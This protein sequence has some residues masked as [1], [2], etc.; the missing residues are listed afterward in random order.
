ME[1]LPIPIH[2]DED[3][4]CSFLSEEVKME[5]EKQQSFGDPNIPTGECHFDYMPSETIDHIL[6]FI[7]Y[8]PDWQK[9]KLLSKR[10]L[11]LGMEAFDPTVNK[12]EP[13]SYAVRAFN[14]D[15]VKAILS[16]KKMDVVT[17]KVA[18][19]KIMITSCKS[20]SHKILS[21]LL[22]ALPVDRTIWLGLPFQQA[23]MNGTNHVRG[24]FLSAIVSHQSIEIEDNLR[25]Y[26]AVYS[27]MNGDHRIMEAILKRE[28]PIDIGEVL[29]MASL[30]LDGIKRQGNYDMLDLPD[31]HTI[32]YDK[33]PCAAKHDLPTIMLLDCARK[34]KYNID[35]ERPAMAH[36]FAYPNLWASLVGVAVIHEKVS[37][38]D[39]LL[40]HEHAEITPKLVLDIQTTSLT[41]STE[42]G[43]RLLRD[44]R[45]L[46]GSDLNRP[47]Q[48]GNTMFEFVCRIGTTEMVRLYLSHEGLRL[49]ESGDQPIVAAL[50]RENHSVLALLI[51]DGRMVPT[52]RHL[53]TAICMKKWKHVNELLRDTRV[54]PNSTANSRD[55]YPFMVALEIKEDGAD[56][57]KN[58]I[59]NLFSKCKRFDPNIGYGYLLK[60]AIILNEREAITVLTRNSKF[61]PSKHPQALRHA[62]Q[63][64]DLEIIRLVVREVGLP[65]SQSS[66]HAL[67]K[68]CLHDAT[69][70][71]FKELLIWKDVRKILLDD[72]TLAYDIWY[73]APDD[74]SRSDMWNYPDLIAEISTYLAKNQRFGDLSLVMKSEC[75]S[76]SAQLESIKPKKKVNPVKIDKCAP[77]PKKKRRK[78]ERY[79]PPDTDSENGISDYIP[80]SEE[81]EKVI[82]KPKKKAKKTTKKKST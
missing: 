13:L 5:E 32:G 82:E 18:Y 43:V 42:I 47:D 38:L 11:G 26:L 69:P 55:E 49:E 44:K 37:L 59:V 24:T 46:I 29:R 48:N 65:K 33:I 66:R 19:G 51:Q 70:A 15:A 14:L 60:Q 81:E 57:R 71:V 22:G 4:L 36:S 9:V 53:V 41:K 8:G 35:A 50:Q 72:V 52:T 68:A 77:T 58:K 6:S 1:E 76:V 21:A 79:I 27:V 40:R 45:F 63:N 56:N 31:E 39:A 54:D 73:N 34:I 10:F 30:D 61:D 62:C 25:Q 16:H 75:E 23:L 17:H 20:R 3:Y 67:I 28:K 74:Q 80:D 64:G 78:R 2:I 7:P 12:C